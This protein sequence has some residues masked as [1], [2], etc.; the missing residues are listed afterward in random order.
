[1]G[2]FYP[3]F[4]VFLMV[5][6]VYG[7]E[8]SKAKKVLYINSYNSGM[9]WSD[10][11][12]KGIISELQ[13]TNIELFIEYL[14]SKRFGQTRFPILEEY[15]A[16][17]YQSISF[18][19]IIV[20]DND[21]LDFVIQYGDM[22]FPEIPVVFCGINEPENYQFEHTRF[23]GFIE[24]ADPRNTLTLITTL[25]PEAKRVLVIADNTTT[26]KVIKNSFKALEPVFQ[27]LKIDF[28]ESINIDSLFQ[29]VKKGEITDV[30]SLNTVFQDNEGNLVD[31]PGFQKKIAAISPK[32]VFC[33]W[34]PLGTGI[35][36]EYTNSGFEQG[37]NAAVM[38]KDIFS[39]ANLST[40][41]HVN[42]I[43]KISYF[44]YKILKKFG[45][46]PK[47]LPK[48]AV[49]LNKP[50]VKYRRYLIILL[51][52]TTG[53]L[54]I[55]LVLIFTV[56]KRISAEELVR[57]QVVEI[58]QKKKQLEDS[59]EQLR[60]LN[61]ELEKAN[62][63]L[64]NYNDSLIDAMKLAEESER[65]K[66]SFLANMSHEIRTP[67]NAIVG[68]STLLVE[69][70]LVIEK[71]EDFV[72]IIQ[73]SCDTLLVLIDDILD[74]SRIDSGQLHL[75]IERISIQDVFKELLQFVELRNC[76]NL[77][78]LSVP[79]V[80]DSSVLLNTDKVRFKQILTNFLTNALKF[81]ENGTDTRFGIKPYF[82]T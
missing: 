25:F 3:L 77:D 26:G 60:E 71:R 81:I 59:Y 40:L 74:L 35:I 1:M 2:F 38:A 39:N 32:P 44:D 43:K 82:T 50:I 66:S 41:K 49:V 5:G 45:V 65:L 58:Q 72:N 6:N 24:T 37:L 80:I 68:F 8:H 70:E 48:D 14:D 13:G 27:K 29:V 7:T 61:A 15:I 34:Q 16:K 17:K 28:V 75:N 18:D 53:L 67:L 79:S 51:F 36:G 22:L 9:A 56:R 20:S 62:I 21:A 69:K 63:K 10:S 4:M 30:I 33:N 46:S 52:I 12:T 23:Y 64:Y 57:Q 54:I 31:Y 73:S 42:E 55:V 11:I 19:A 78:I 47:L 76:N